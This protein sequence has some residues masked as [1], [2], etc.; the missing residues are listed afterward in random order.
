MSSVPGP[1]PMVSLFFCIFNYCVP[2]S[3][4]SPFTDEGDEGRKVKSV[5]QGHSKC[6]PRLHCAKSWQICPPRNGHIVSLSIGWLGE[7]RQPHPLL[8]F[9]LIHSALHTCVMKYAWFCVG[10][11]PGDLHNIL[12]CTCFPL[13][14]ITFTLMSLAQFR[15]GRTAYMGR[16]RE[17]EFDMNLMHGLLF[18]CYFIRLSVWKVFSDHAS[19]MNGFRW[20]SF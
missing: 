5:V 9:F 20:W 19:G 2:W 18:F 7:C 1:V 16:A 14:N 4:H 11:V 13:F 10:L 8:F 6:W 15:K 3:H 17:H 12:L